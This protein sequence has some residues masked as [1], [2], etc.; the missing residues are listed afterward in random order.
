MLVTGHLQDG[1][2]NLNWDSLAHSDQTLVFYM[3]L[4][5]VDTAFDSSRLNAVLAFPLSGRAPFVQTW[6]EFNAFFDKMRGAGIVESIRDKG[7]PVIAHGVIGPPEECIVAGY[8][9]GGDRRHCA[10]SLNRPKIILPAVVCSTL[11]TTTSIV[12]PWAF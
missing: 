10:S 6:E 2:V 1:S 3:G 4:Q 9:E 8:D 11:V 7:R 12:L 5:G